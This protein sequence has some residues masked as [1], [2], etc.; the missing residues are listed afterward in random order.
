MY[1]IATNEA[2]EALSLANSTN[3]IQVTKFRLGDITPSLPNLTTNPD[4]D[5][6]TLNSQVFLNNNLV[7]KYE[8]DE[9]QISYNPVNPNRVVLKCYAPPHI[10][11]TFRYDSV[12][13]FVEHDGEEFIFSL[14]YYNQLNPKF[15]IEQ[16]EGGMQYYFLL[17]L[18]L[19]NI[20]DLFDFTNLNRQEVTFLEGDDWYTLPVAHKELKDQGILQ[21]HH[22][23]PN[24]NPHLIVNSNEVWY[25]TFMRPVI[26]DGISRDLLLPM[27]GDYWPI[28]NQTIPDGYRAKLNEDG[29]FVHDR[30][31][32]ELMERI[33]HAGYYVLEID[34]VPQLYN[35]REILIDRPLP[36]YPYEVDGN[37]YPL[38]DGNG[39]L[40]PA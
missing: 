32:N 19:S 14:H 1:S 17:T 9:D 28:V 26:M 11:D 39:Q 35:G 38:R 3:K 40:I 10:A 29:S 36:D 33:P 37:N 2:K 13:L 20:N 6:S 8:G 34:G 18:E 16:T 30:D 25:G 7:V 31:G 5:V 21:K 15:N 4:T 12:L 24:S 27:V 22:N 23:T